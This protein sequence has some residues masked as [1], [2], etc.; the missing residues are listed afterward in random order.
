MHSTRFCIINLGCKVNRV[1][2]D[3]V[4]AALMNAGGI[5]VEEGDADLV[6]VNTCTVTGEADKK[7]RK[8]VRRALK[9]APRA[10]VVVTG[11]AVAIDAESY[12]T[13]SDRVEVVPR[14]DLLA[15]IAPGTLMPLRLGEGF[16]T[17]VSVKVQDGCDR[18]CTYCIVHVA[19]GRAT[20]VPSCDILAECERYLQQDVKEIVL[21]GIDLGS[22]RDAGDYRLEHL[23]EDLLELVDRNTA[24]G[25][26]PA[27]VRASSL[28][29]DSVSERFIDLLATSQGRLCRHL[30][31]PLQ[32][33]STKV[34]R[35][36]ARPYSAE[37][38]AE[39]VEYI[40]A[41]VPMLSLT[42]DIICGFPGEKEGEFEE[43]L[44]LARRCR[45]SKVHVFPYSMRSGTPAAARADQVPSEV[46]SARASR[47]RKL[48]SDLRAADLARRAGTT[49]LALV[50]GA[51]A[52]TESYHELP[53]PGGAVPGLLI[54][55][56][57][58]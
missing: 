15:S 27:R 23:V 52:L 32:A 20:S 3:T 16:R 46:K 56:I 40:Y 50:E 25:E 10:K 37:D 13:L 4:A 39:L 5:A 30:H 12:A 19:R 49:E 14:A 55:L 51:T 45:F 35:E 57:L 58:G 38:F 9:A 34:L 42:T 1:E 8:A 44:D 2:S 33:G 53:A 48:A 11:C 36:M 24:A 7:A 29:P 54:P 6:I 43:T 21:T 41:R 17:R 18:A 26:I 22:Y 47:L 28:E 31:L